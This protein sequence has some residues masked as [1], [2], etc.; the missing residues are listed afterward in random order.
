MARYLPT[1]CIVVEDDP[2]WMSEVVN[3]L[4]SEEV[5]IFRA[6]RATDG[7]R[8]LDQHPEASMVIDIILPEQDGLELM[9]DARQKFPDLKVLAISGG[10]RLGADFYLKLAD[11]FGADAVIEKPFT[12]EQLVA[13]WRQ[14]RAGKKP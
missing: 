4:A 14:A 10:G 2:F 9:R 6:S 7:L 12:A 3:G 11:A 1:K 8:L 13:G 5:E